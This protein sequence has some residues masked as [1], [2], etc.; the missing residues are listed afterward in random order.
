MTSLFGNLLS[1][2][3]EDLVD[4]ATSENLPVG[5][6]DIVSNLDIAD[7]IKS[8]E[9]SAK[10]AIQSF[11][12]RINHKNPNVQLLA[13]K[14]TDTCVKNSGHHFL[15]EVASREFI[16]NLVS[17]SRSLMNPNTDVKQKILALIQAWGITFKSK[18]DLSFV[19]EIYEA[20]KKEGVIFPPIDAA[21]TAAAIIDTQTVPDWTDSELCMRCRTAFTTFNRK[22]HCRNCGKTYC[23]DCSS[24]RIPLAHLGITEPVRVCDTCHTKL[25]TKSPANTNDFAKANS[26]NSTTGLGASSTTST[27]SSNA[28]EDLAKKEDEDL[29]KAIA[30]SL[31][32]TNDSGVSSSASRKST[33]KQ[34]VRFATQDQESDEDLKRAIEASLRDAERSTPVQRNSNLY[35]SPPD[36]Q[37]QSS[38]YGSESKSFSERTPTAVAVVD[39]SNDISP[40]E[41]ENIRLFSELVERTEADILSKGITNLN[42]AQLQA[43]L[44]QVSPLQVKL[45]SSIEVAANKYKTL[46]DINEQINDAVKLYDQFLK[47]RLTFSQ[48]QHSSVGIP[49]GHPYLA[50]VPSAAGVYASPNTQQQPQKQWGAPA[51][52]SNAASQPYQIPG[53]LSYPPHATFIPGGSVPGVLQPVQQQPAYPPSHNYGH[54]PSNLAPG[55]QYS[56]GAPSQPESNI[57]LQVSNGVPYQPPPSDAHVAQPQRHTQQ[58]PQPVV[59][60]APLIEL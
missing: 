33:T 19:C 9:V 50:G 48:Q 7:K 42:P 34:S 14:L 30:A 55:S 47:Q 53:S 26:A 36:H 28:H 59:Q 56:Y 5:T 12:R 35:G 45:H 39:S 38:L 21:D 16:D 2:P 40:T 58:P 8:K 18:P 24:K 17:I 44:T 52:D 31:G 29:A 3:F 4:K 1:N 46:Y 6:D 60:E 22:H 37:Q 54:P 32:T 57:A 23:N 51:V 27:A 25:A 41:L 10:T 49:Y 13:L 15:Q 20:M 43:L 11:K